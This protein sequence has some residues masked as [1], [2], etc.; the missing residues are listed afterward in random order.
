MA[1]EANQGKASLAKLLTGV[2]LT[3]VEVQ[4]T[5]SYIIPQQSPTC[6]NKDRRK[7]AD[8]ED[9]ERAN[10]KH[11]LLTKARA[12]E[13]SPTDAAPFLIL[14]KHFDSGTETPQSQSC[15]LKHHIPYL[16]CAAPPMG[17]G[18]ARASKAGAGREREGSPHQTSRH[19]RARAEHGARAT[20]EVAR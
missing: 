12:K 17:T 18:G 5:T 4:Q 9:L 3:H 6:L 20:L 2:N 10:L 11:K 7:L 13:L 14:T 8:L 15:G 1:L 19:G 16:L